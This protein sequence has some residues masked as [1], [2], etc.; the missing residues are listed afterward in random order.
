MITNAFHKANYVFCDSISIELI[1][2]LNR[3]IIINT[4]SANF[5][6]E[7]RMAIMFR[8]K[9]INRCDLKQQRVKDTGYGIVYENG[10]SNGRLSMPLVIHNIIEIMLPPRKGNP[11]VFVELWPSYFTRPKQ[12]ILIDEKIN[13]D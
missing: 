6:R 3:P 12:W 8:T 7:S 11:R 2:P 10:K 9:D 5:K 4:D 1:D 13:Q